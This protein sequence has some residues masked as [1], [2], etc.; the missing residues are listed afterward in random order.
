MGLGNKSECKPAVD[1]CEFRTTADKP[2]AS[3]LLAVANSAK[4]LI[5]DTSHTA[6]VHLPLN[7]S[8]TVS[9]RNG[10][11]LLIWLVFESI[12]AKSHLPRPV[13]HLVGKGRCAK[14]HPSDTRF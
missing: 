13:I 7:L 10:A 3:P 12:L 2:E 5:H 11:G 4:S 1:F 8:V 9:F 14:E 6:F